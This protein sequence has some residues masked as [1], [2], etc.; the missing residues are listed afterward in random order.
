MNSCNVS[1]RLVGD[2]AAI[3]AL[4]SCMP[5]VTTSLSAVSFPC[6]VEDHGTIIVK[7][8]RVSLSNVNL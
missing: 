3:A 4:F 2:I 6:N 1:Q 7:R 8:A 5:R